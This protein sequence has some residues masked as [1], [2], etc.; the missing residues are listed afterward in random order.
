MECERAREVK[1]KAD[2]ER[3]RE[4]KNAKDHARKR[5][6]LRWG[7]ETP[8]RCEYRSED[9]YREV[10]KGPTAQPCNAST[11]NDTD[12]F[13]NSTE[14][15]AKLGLS[16]IKTAQIQA[17]DSRRRAMTLRLSDN[18][19]WSVKYCRFAALKSIVATTARWQSVKG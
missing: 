3:R 4:M 16:S 1:R 11:F 8:T 18:Q 13:I 10:E 7:G 6:R 12:S 9:R 19:W 5:H 17:C 2:E 14:A 15:N